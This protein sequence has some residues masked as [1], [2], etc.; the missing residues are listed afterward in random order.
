MIYTHILSRHLMISQAHPRKKEE[1]MRRQPNQTKVNDTHMVKSG[2]Y[3][4]D[5][6]RGSI[7]RLG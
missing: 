4:P 3:Q 2:Y 6:I 1:P 5:Y 7:L